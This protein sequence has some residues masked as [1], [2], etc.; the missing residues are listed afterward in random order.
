MDQQDLQNLPMEQLLNQ[1]VAL[2]FELCRRF[3]FVLKHPSH[4]QKIWRSLWFVASIAATAARGALADLLHM[5]ATAV[6][7]TATVETD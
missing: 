3:V 4:S 2:I 6:I 7:I 1:I 5:G